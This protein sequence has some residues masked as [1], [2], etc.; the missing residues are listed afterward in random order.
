ME[1]AFAII[2]NDSDPGAEGQTGWIGWGNHT[3][4]FGKNPEEMQTLVLQ[5][6]VLPVDA[7]GRLATM[8]GDLKR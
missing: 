5:N 6:D 7:A 8:W 4:V 2:A 3:I 1:I